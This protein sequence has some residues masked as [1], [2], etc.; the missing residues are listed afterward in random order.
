[1][2]NEVQIVKVRRIGKN[3]EQV[4]HA[5]SVISGYYAMYYDECTGIIRYEPVKV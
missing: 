2:P 3:A 5:P 4:L 1:M